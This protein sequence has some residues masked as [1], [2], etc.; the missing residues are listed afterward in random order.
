MEVHAGDR[1]QFTGDAPEDDEVPAPERGLRGTV[2]DPDFDGGCLV[3]WDVIEVTTVVET[4][5]LRPVGESDWLG[6]ALRAREEQDQAA[7]L[8]APDW[9][10]EE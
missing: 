5:D 10:Y 8:E 4:G 7:Q 6:D 1:V 2:V 9:P 3:E